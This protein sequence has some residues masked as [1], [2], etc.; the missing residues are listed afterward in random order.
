MKKAILHLFVVI[1]IA[2]A[3]IGQSMAIGMTD[4]VDMSGMMKVCLN[5]DH[6]MDQPG[7]TCIDGGCVANGC[8]SSSVS[9]VFFFTETVSVSAPGDLSSMH[10][11]FYQGHYLSQIPLPLYRPP[12]T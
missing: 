11:H 3:P 5:C 9:S 7:T 8:V 10:G 4:N 1:S 2:F 6:D 12:I